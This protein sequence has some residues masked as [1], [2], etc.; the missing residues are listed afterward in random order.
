MGHQRLDERLSVHVTGRLPVVHELVLQLDGPRPLQLFCPYRVG[1]RDGWRPSL[2][3]G[4]LLSDGS[5]SVLGDSPPGGSRVDGAAS[6]VAAT[7]VLVGVVR[8]DVPGGGFGR[9]VPPALEPRDPGALDQGDA[10][11]SDQASSNGG[12]TGRCPVKSRT[13]P[14]FRRVQVPNGAPVWFQRWRSGIRVSGLI[15]PPS[16]RGGIP[17]RMKRHAWC[18]L[19]PIAVRLRSPNVLRQRSLRFLRS[20]LPTSWPIRVS[21]SPRPGCLS[22]R[23]DRRA[24]LS[25]RCCPTA[26]CG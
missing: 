11:V 2:A 19:P 25:L 24:V 21:V 7:G 13:L 18:S 4:S 12:S 3:G 14:G 1:P 15:G 20:R 5:F 16:N 17:R 8:L 10:R 23:C 6:A 9:Q 22:R 26:R